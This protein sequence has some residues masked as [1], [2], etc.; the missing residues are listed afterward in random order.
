MGSQVMQVIDF[1]SHA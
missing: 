1:S